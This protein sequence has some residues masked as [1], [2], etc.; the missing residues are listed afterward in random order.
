MKIREMNYQVSTQPLGELVSMDITVSVKKR[1]YMNKKLVAI[2]AFGLITIGIEA[3]A[4]LVYDYT[5][6]PFDVRYSA[7][8]GDR[9]IASVT[10]SDSITSGYN[11]VTAATDILSWSI[12][13]GVL[14]FTSKNTSL[15]YGPPSFSPPTLDWNTFRFDNGHIVEWNF[16]ALVSAAEPYDI[17]NTV[18]SPGWAIYD[19]VTVPGPYQ[20]EYIAGQPGTWTSNAAPVPIPAAVWLFGS[21]IAGLGVVIRKLQ[22]HKLKA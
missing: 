17:V 3:D 10:F 1:N 22:S 21:T 16:T 9:I 2:L 20:T 7:G 8:L 15:Y 12:S 5:G 18:N 19:S 13:T 11:G 4:S 6:N 14:T